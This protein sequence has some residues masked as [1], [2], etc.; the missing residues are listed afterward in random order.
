MRKALIMED[1]FETKLNYRVTFTNMGKFNLSI[2]KYL[3]IS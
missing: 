1:Q 3:H 2:D